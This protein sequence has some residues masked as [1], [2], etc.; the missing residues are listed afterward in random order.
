MQSTGGQRFTV[1]V[2]FRVIKYSKGLEKVWD[3]YDEEMEEDG[4]EG[5]SEDDKQSQ[6]QDEEGP[7]LL[8]SSK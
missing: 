3:L 6:K 1:Y 4:Q 8:K 7:I 2:Y 5:G